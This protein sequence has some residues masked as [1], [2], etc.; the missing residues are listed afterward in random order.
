M[1]FRSGNMLAGL[2]GGFSE[3][4]EPA[5]LF[6]GLFGIT[7]VMAVVLMALTPTIKRMMGGVH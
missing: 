4:L 1:L 2:A 5:T 3:H 7:T 6:G